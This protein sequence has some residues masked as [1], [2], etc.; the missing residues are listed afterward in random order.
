MLAHVR[1]TFPLTSL[2]HSFER[3]A[4]WFLK[5]RGYS[6]FP[7]MQSRQKIVNTLLMININPIY[8]RQFRRQMYVVQSYLFTSGK[9]QKP[10]LYLQQTVNKLL[11]M[12]FIGVAI[13]LAALV[14]WR[15][16]PVSSCY[17]SKLP[18][19]HWYNSH[20]NRN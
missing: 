8:K 5:I 7:H 4:Y 14:N 15:R 13:K 12:F 10:G 18:Q 19:K 3:R 9:K 17:S 16:T 1:K 2:A 6:L 20:N 11:N